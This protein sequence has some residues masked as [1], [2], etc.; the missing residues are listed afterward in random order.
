MD[1]DLEL[2]Q[3]Y[4]LD[5]V[6]LN[7]TDIQELKKVLEQELASRIDLRNKELEYQLALKVREQRMVRLSKVPLWKASVLDEENEIP[8]Y[9]IK[10]KAQ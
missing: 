8:S 5:I 7:E 6:S 9:T 10:P 4:N 3:K 1:K 2:L